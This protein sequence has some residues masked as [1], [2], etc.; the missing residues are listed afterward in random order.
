MGAKAPRKYDKS[1]EPMPGFRASSDVKR[2][3]A[4]QREELHEKEKQKNAA[5]RLRAAGFEFDRFIKNAA[6]YTK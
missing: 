5:K 3:L 4:D 6:K 2:K 1:W